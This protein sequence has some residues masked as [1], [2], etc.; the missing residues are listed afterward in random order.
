MPDKDRFKDL[1]KDWYEEPDNYKTPKNTCI[2]HQ[3]KTKKKYHAKV[4]IKCQ[5]EIER[6]KD[7]GNQ[8]YNPKD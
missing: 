8:N 6:K 5:I 1:D 4:V 3:T 7:Q 2:K